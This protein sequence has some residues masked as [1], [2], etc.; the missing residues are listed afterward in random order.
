MERERGGGCGRGVAR[1][2]RRVCSVV[3]RRERQGRGEARERVRERRGDS[4]GYVWQRQ[5][6]PGE[7]GGGG[8]RVRRAQLLLCLLARGRRRGCPWGTGPPGVLASRAVTARGQV[9]QVGFS[10]CSSFCFINVFYY[11][12][13][14]RALLKMPGHYQKS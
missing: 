9:S 11:S 6:R 1:R 5:R 7:Q 3:P 13:N 14:F 12:V 8:A 4:R 2:R 10:L